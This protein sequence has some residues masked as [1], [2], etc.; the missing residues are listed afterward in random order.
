MPRKPTA[1]AATPSTTS[2]CRRAPGPTSRQ[3]AEADPPA[4][5]QPT[6][7]APRVVVVARPESLVQESF[8]GTDGAP[9]DEQHR[10]G[11]E[12]QPPDR[13]R[14]QRDRD[15]QHQQADIE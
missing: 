5:S 4:R 7:D 14:E 3:P 2:G 13:G 10:D 1:R 6:T 12:E 9:V 15:V 11:E 8:L